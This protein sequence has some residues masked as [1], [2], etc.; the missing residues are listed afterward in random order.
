MSELE[1]IRAAAKDP[2]HLPAIVGR[3]Q[4]SSP[5][6]RRDWAGGCPKASGGE[7]EGDALEV[8]AQAVQHH[9]WRLALELRGRH[10]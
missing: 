7:L 2:P 1:L 6:A 9:D 4:S 3:K 5:N 10:P 8:G